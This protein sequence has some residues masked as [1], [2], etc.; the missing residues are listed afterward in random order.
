MCRRIC[1]KWAKYSQN[2]VERSQLYFNLSKCAVRLRTT[3]L[4][5][6][7]TNNGFF[8]GV[9]NSICKI[10]SMLYE[11]QGLQ[12]TLPIP[13]EFTQDLEGKSFLFTT[14]TF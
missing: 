11:V 5:D 4:A 14:T 7:F 1:P 9:Q 6:V 2:I 8:W 10:T 12:K 3:E 13:S